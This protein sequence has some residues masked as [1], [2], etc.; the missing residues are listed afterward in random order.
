MTSERKFKQKFQ[1]K[2]DFYDS[3]ILEINQ[4]YT[5]EWEKSEELGI[6]KEQLEKWKSLLDTLSV[7]VDDRSKRADEIFKLINS[8]KDVTSKMQE[9]NDINVQIRDNQKQLKSLDVSEWVSACI[10]DVLWEDISH[11][12]ILKALNYIGW[13][14]DDLKTAIEESVKKNEENGILKEKYEQCIVYIDNYLNGL[15]LDDS[16]RINDILKSDL[17]YQYAE[18]QWN[19]D[20]LQKMREKKLTYD[21]Y[22]DILIEVNPLYAYIVHM[23]NIS[24]SEVDKQEYYWILEDLEKW[25]ISWDDKIDLDDKCNK[26]RRYKRWEK[27]DFMEEIGKSSE[28]ECIDINA[29]VEKIPDRNTDLEAVDK[30]KKLLADL[31]WKNFS[32][33]ELLL[34]ANKFRDKNRPIDLIQRNSF[35]KRVSDLQQ[36]KKDKDVENETWWVFESEVAKS[37]FESRKDHNVEEAK[38]FIEK[39]EI[40]LLVDYLEYFKWLDKNVFDE[41][42]KYYD[43]NTGN[44]DKFINKLKFI[45]KVCENLWSFNPEIADYILIKFLDRNNFESSELRLIL[46]RWGYEHWCDLVCKLIDKGYFEDLIER[47]GR[48]FESK[49]KFKRFNSEVAHKIIDK[50]EEYKWPKWEKCDWRHYVATHLQYFEGL[51]ADIRKELIGKYKWLVEKYKDS[52]VSDSDEMV[53]YTTEDY[54]QFIE[55]K[56]WKV[57]DDKIKTLAQTDWLDYMAILNKLLEKKHG[58]II[59]NNITSFKWVDHNYIIKK[60]EEKDLGFLIPKNLEKFEW[61]NH[62]DIANELM[63]TKRYRIVPIYL[64]K[65]EWLDH[66]DIAIKLIKK[67][68]TICLFD[69]LANFKELDL[70]RFDAWLFKKYKWVKNLIDE[71]IRWWQVGMKWG[72]VAKNISSFRKECHKEIADI[73]IDKWEWAYVPVF[74]KNFTWL[75]E[76]AKKNIAIRLIENWKRESVENHLGNFEFWKETNEDL[77]EKIKEKI[78][79]NIKET[80]ENISKKKVN[81]LGR[82]PEEQAKNILQKI[83]QITSK[84][85]NLNKKIDVNTILANLMEKWSEVEAILENI[86]FD[87][88]LLHALLEESW[89]YGALLL[90]KYRRNFGLTKDRIWTVLE[91][92]L[93]HQWKIKQQVHIILADDPVIDEMVGYKNSIYLF[94]KSWYA[95]SFNI[96]KYF[97]KMNDE[98]LEEIADRLEQH[99]ERWRLAKHLDKF[100]WVN[101]QDL[102]NE[103]IAKG[104]W[105]SLAENL[106]KFEW[107]DPE[108]IAN[109]LIKSWQWKCV[110]KFLDKFKW[111]NHSEIKNVADTLTKQWDLQIVPWELDNFEFKEEEKKELVNKIMESGKWAFLEKCLWKFEGLDRVVAKGLIEHGI[112]YAVAS[113]PEV[114]QPTVFKWEEGRGITKDLID[115]GCWFWIAEHPEFFEWLDMSIAE[116]LIKGK[117]YEQLVS[118]IKNF[119]E[120]NH[121]EIA[122]ELIDKGFWSLVKENLGN[123]QLSDKETIMR[124]L[125]IRGDVTNDEIFNRKLRKIFKEHKFWISDLYEKLGKWKERNK[126]SAWWKF[127]ETLSELLEKLW[128]NSEF[129]KELEWDLDSQESYLL[130]LLESEEKW[131]HYYELYKNHKKFEKILEETVNSLE[132]VL[133]NDDSLSDKEKEKIESSFEDIKSELLGYLGESFVVLLHNNDWNLQIDG[134]QLKELYNDLKESDRTKVTKDYLCEFLGQVY[135]VE[136]LN[137]EDFLEDSEDGQLENWEENLEYSVDL[138]WRIERSFKTIWIIGEKWDNFKILLWEDWWIDKEN[139][140]KWKEEYG[141]ELTDNFS[142]ILN[143]FWL[144]ILEKGKLDANVSSPQDF[145]EKMERLWFKCKNKKIFLQNL[146]LAWNQISNMQPWLSEVLKKLDEYYDQ[147]KSVMDNLNDPLVR[148][149]ATNKNPDFYAIKLPNG[150]QAPR[151]ILSDENP[152]KILTILSHDN[153]NQVRWDKKTKKRIPLKGIENRIFW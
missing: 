61:V 40:D 53:N 151:I 2:R 9:V 81:N 38:N 3:K 99:G 135:N 129:I 89:G 71:L 72:W 121:E 67:D 145:V 92:S 123:F 27:S 150:N 46:L 88:N 23:I 57:L 80:K 143:H 62:V 55:K 153:Y 14:L 31:Q 138:L 100:K 29:I 11:D 47:F 44:K 8:G 28:N 21:E 103:M 144:K 78:D 95:K 77:E 20:V 30:V 91:K 132:E 101:H 15:K 82:T 139:F 134:T 48:R 25:I 107:I 45:N 124:E 118:N 4:N 13:E 130:Q 97:A 84:G 59:L 34:L 90:L 116:I 141:F 79:E 152:H 136:I 122:L 52:F 128:W 96:D 60:L 125:N 140:D 117:K 85:K 115:G 17:V 104:K 64:D 120:E 108:I 86:N 127:P 41:L 68:N 114:F 76:L 7:L 93:C 39:G 83:G 18:K 12:K 5:A 36:Q 54:I 109:Q 111:V 75:D 32:D 119:N 98:D 42:L 51:D 137:R 131:N 24:Q 148:I 94:I 50:V 19:K 6:K 74:I 142:K 16:D 10:A 110:V 43:E 73:L 1:Q 49:P 33:E 149:R 105:M 58:D 66:N 113:H 102:A 106:H 70:K 112:R 147:E 63:E 69:N 56:R 146:T 26:R 65:F 35:F 37:E 87:D 22:E 126:Q 133:K